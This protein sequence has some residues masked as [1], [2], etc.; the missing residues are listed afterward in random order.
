M[1]SDVCKHC[2]TAP[3]QQACPTGAIVSTE[4]ANVY[5]HAGV[6][7]GCAYC[8]AACPFGVITRSGF[9]G[10]SHK[11][12]LCYDRQTAGM[13]PACAKACP[14]QSI[15][16]GPVD[17]LRARARQRVEELHRGGVAGAYL[18]GDAATDTYSELH[19]FY[20]LVDRPSV[21]GL[22]E[23]PVNPWRHMKGDYA[24]ALGGALAAVAALLAVLLTL[25]R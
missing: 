11:C 25:G 16:F 24:R 17:D 15:R 14:T 13:V 4:F 2:V 18:Y 20:L 1:M 3:C 10:H 8:V 23:N 6:C 12:T 7:N 9:D 5:I 21:Y 19:S 22:P